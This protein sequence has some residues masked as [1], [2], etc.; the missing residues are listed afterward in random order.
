[1]FVKIIFKII[2]FIPFNVLRKLSFV[3]GVLLYYVPNYYKSVSKINL[4]MA[5]PNKNRKEI[6][7]LTF[8]SLKD[9]SRVLLE[10]SKIWYSRGHNYLVVEGDEHIK[11]SLKKKAGA[12]LFTPHLGNIESII[13]FLGQNFDCSIPY[14]PSK[15]TSF[16]KVM[17][18]ARE[19]L[20]VT[21]VKADFS[22][23]KKLYTALR[24][25]GLIAI[26][27]DQV[28][29]K[30]NGIISNFFSKPALTMTL[31]S[32][33]VKKTKCPCHSVYCL[34][35][36]EGGSYKIV[37]SKQMDFLQNLPHK[38]FINLMNRELEKCIMKAP[39]QYSWEYKRYKHSG[40]LDPY[41]Q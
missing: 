20:G 1:M 34:R 30:K 41:K 2:S 40:P 27:S 13:G 18:E 35:E 38:D 24:E 31:V 25:G 11:S 17:L 12:V 10:I 5:F 6:K 36:K 16:E 37:F 32:S 22:G 7:E 9:S 8:N 19:N 28:P 39:E 33:L 21:M 26:A 15:K 4:N 3:L 29:N 23:I 14:T